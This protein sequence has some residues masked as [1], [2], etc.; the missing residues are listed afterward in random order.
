MIQKARRIWTQRAAI[1]PV[2]ATLLLV[3]IAVAA[4][5]LTQAWVTS[6]IKN[7]GSGAQTAIRIEM[8]EFAKNGANNDWVNMTIRNVGS[9]A[10]RIETLYI[11][12]NGTTYVQDY[13]SDN[14]LAVGDK[15]KMSFGT[16]EVPT[17]FAWVASEAFDIKVVTDNG[18]EVDGTFFTPATA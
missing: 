17:G 9:T 18:F 6:M 2:I 10:T 3:A 11:T 14:V 8:V 16:A 4:A 1:S 5:I 15:V 12:F 13:V 7:Q